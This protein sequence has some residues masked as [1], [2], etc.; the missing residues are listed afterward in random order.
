MITAARG[1]IAFLLIWVGSEYG[2]QG[3]PIAIWLMLAD[4]AGDVSDGPIARRSS[5]QYHT[6]IGDHDLEIDMTVSV[7]LLIYMLQ[8]GQGGILHAFGMIFQTPIY[9]WFIYLA[10]RDAPQIGWLIPTFIAA[11]VAVTWPRF[12]RV[13]VPGF[14]NQVRGQNQ[15]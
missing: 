8:S 12:P 15:H 7:G 11:A 3:L 1:I 6:W 5:R 10:L 9:G 13:I 14:L 4:W 2:A